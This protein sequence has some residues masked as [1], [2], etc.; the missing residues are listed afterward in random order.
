M[1][2][3]A[4]KAIACPIVTSST[5]L[6]DSVEHGARMSHVTEG[7]TGSYATEDG[8]LYSRWNSPTCDVVARS[9]ALLEGI[10]DESQGG[11]RLFASGMAAMSSAILASLKQVYKLN[12][13]TLCLCSLLCW[14]TAD[15]AIT[16][17]HHT[18]S[19]A[20]FGNFWNRSCQRKWESRL[21][22]TVICCSE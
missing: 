4:L 21:A 13:F 8:Y 18:E 2:A 19:M 11:C 6:L 15:R 7:A 22:K 10:S 9:V 12:F 20:V 17:L 5:F 1:P 14:L 3:G 16:S